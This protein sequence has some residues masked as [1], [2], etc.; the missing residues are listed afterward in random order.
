M[1]NY[2]RASQAVLDGSRGIDDDAALFR[3]L[4]VSHSSHRAF[5]ATCQD[6][7]YTYEIQHA[8][9]TCAY[10]IVA[11]QRSELDLMPTQQLQTLR[12]SRSP[13]VARLWAGPG[14]AIESRLS[15]QQVL[16]LIH[17]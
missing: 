13:F 10:S 9:G 12:A 5:L 14:L 11:H 17:I 8:L 15:E 2:E 7:T 16:S 1:G 4:D 6:E 3:D